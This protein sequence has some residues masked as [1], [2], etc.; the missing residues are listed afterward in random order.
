MYA[1]LKNGPYCFINGVIFFS[2]QGSESGKQSNNT[3][4]EFLNAL[5]HVT[6]DND[7]YICIAQ[8]C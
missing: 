5:L 2:E 6:D 1:E 8:G 3:L 7:I 4:P